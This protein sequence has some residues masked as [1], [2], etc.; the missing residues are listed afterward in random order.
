[1][2][3][4]LSFIDVHLLVLISYLCTQLVGKVHNVKYC[5]CKKHI[6]L[7]QFSFPLSDISIHASIVLNVL[8]YRILGAQR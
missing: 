6:T 3:N 7:L 4:I 2:Y 8:S 5:V 1:V